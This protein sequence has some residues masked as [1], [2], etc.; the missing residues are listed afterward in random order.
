MIDLWFELAIYICSVSVDEYSNETA[1]SAELFECEVSLPTY[2]V[3]SI[4]LWMTFAP[5][6]C[7]TVCSYVYSLTKKALHHRL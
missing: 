4:I 2:I 3:T 1:L 7:K 5:H 6:H